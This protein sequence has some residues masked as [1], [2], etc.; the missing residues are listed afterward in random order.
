MDR[1][2]QPST[3]R[4]TKPRPTLPNPQRHAMA[5]LI[6]SKMPGVTMDWK[7]GH[8]KFLAAG[9]KF[10]TITREGDLA[11]ALPPERM[12]ELMGNGEATAMM[13]GKRVVE[14]VVVID[15]KADPMW[16]F[17]L[18]KEARHFAESKRGKDNK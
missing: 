16:A 3:N 5:A 17:E 9:N 8:G 12:E 18:L 15:P 10:C 14:G 13:F 4:K 1:T 2:Q 7:S 6:L 11:I